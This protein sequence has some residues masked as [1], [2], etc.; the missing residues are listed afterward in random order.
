VFALPPF[1]DGEKQG[2]RFFNKITLG[3][4]KKQREQLNFL[5]SRFEIKHQRP[6]KLQL[7]LIKVNYEVHKVFFS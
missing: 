7:N 3:E 2:K 1:R 4:R 6:I 5:Q